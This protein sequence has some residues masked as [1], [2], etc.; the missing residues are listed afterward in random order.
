[1]KG[2]LANGDDGLKDFCFSLLVCGWLMKVN[3]RERGITPN[4]KYVH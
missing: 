2:Y 1:M 3:G 4:P